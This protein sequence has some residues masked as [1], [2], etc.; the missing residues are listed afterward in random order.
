[1]QLRITD[2]PKLK[3]YQQSFLEHLLEQECISVSFEAGE[4]VL[5]SSHHSAHFM[6]CEFNLAYF[7]RVQIAPLEY[8]DAWLQHSI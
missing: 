5:T 8:V 3:W 4:I 7:Y 2:C 1:M 6:R